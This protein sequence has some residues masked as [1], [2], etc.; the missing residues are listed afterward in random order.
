MQCSEGLGVSVHLWTHLCMYVPLANE[1][2]Q[3]DS[4]PAHVSH[5]CQCSTT[6]SSTAAVDTTTTTIVVACISNM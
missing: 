6:V 2:S 3:P 1:H 5:E 4:R